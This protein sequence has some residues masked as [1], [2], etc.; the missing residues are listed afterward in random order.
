MTA[1][2]VLMRVNH[3]E[4]EEARL[5]VKELAI[6]E[7]VKTIE[8]CSKL[9]SAKNPPPSEDFRRYINA[10]LLLVAGNHLWSATCPRYNDY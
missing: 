8:M 10:H 9:L 5:M 7:E 4:E 1:V 6:E 3:V 2:T